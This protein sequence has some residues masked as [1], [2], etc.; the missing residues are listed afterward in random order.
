M[1]SRTTMASSINRPMDSDK[2]SRVSMFKVKP[3]IWIANRVPISDTGSV[4][5]VITVLRQLPRNR[6]T[7]STV[8]PAPSSSVDST[9]FSDFFTS[10]A[11]S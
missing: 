9:L 2:A 6:N 10:S 4:R 11:L 3:N 8:R 5:P 7:I 1:F